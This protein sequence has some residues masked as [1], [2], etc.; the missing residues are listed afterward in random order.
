M[1]KKNLLLV[2]LIP[3]VAYSNSKNFN[4]SINSNAEIKHEIFKSEENTLLSS[5]S[6]TSKP[7]I[8]NATSKDNKLKFNVTLKSQRENAYNPDTVFYAKLGKAPEKKIRK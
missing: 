7:F 6:Y 3:F 2:S 5:T 8:F 4:Y 1:K